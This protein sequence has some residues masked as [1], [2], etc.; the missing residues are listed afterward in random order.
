MNLEKELFDAFD[1]VVHGDY[2]TRS[3]KTVPGLLP[4]ES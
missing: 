2:P 3:G 4:F 1:R